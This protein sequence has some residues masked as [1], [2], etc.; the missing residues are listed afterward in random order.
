M[1]L[2]KV[3]FF[4]LLVAGGVWLRWAF[5]D[6]PNFAP[7]AAMA[8]FAGYCIRRPLAAA[9]VPLSI[10]VISDRLI[11]GYQWQMMLL[12][13]AMLTLPVLAGRPLRRSL[14]ER[15]AATFWRPTATV[16]SGSLAASLAFFLVTNFGAWLWFDMYPKTWGGLMESYV[17]AIPF[18]RYTVAGDLFFA[19]ALFAPLMAYR[20]W[21]PAP[22][23]AHAAS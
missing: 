5:R 11:G 10:M 22:H 4:L 3:L 21:S 13:Y 1:K 6:L 8:L 23:L 19:V 9:A 15:S 14:E 17:A 2:A 12:V 20:A 18:F 16:L 7:V